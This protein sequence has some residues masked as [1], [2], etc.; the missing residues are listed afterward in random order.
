M[1]DMAC[2]DVQIDH[3]NHLTEKKLHEGIWGSVVE[4]DPIEG[5]VDEIADGT[6]K[7]QG[8]TH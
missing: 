6:S 2:P 5:A 4:Q 7:N 8:E 3:V 1:C